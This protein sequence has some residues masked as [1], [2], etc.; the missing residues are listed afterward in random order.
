MK[1]QNRSHLQKQS[2][3]H[4]QNVKKQIKPNMLKIKCAKKNN[5]KLNNWYWT[6]TKKL[7]K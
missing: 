3:I 2:T 5:G 1:H 6:G 4:L 7:M